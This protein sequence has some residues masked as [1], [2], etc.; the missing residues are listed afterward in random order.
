MSDGYS[1]FL[2]YA[3]QDDANDRG[4]VLAL[5]EHLEKELSLISGREIRIFVD[6]ASIE[7]GDEWRSRI[8][9]ALNSSVFLIAILTPL[10]FSRVECR[11]ELVEFHAQSRSRGMEKLILPIQYL[12]TP[13][14]DLDSPDELRAIAAR[15]QFEDWTELRLA[16]VDGAD[17]RKGV[18]RLAAFLIQRSEAVR[19]VEEESAR[20]RVPEPDQSRPGLID[21]LESVGPKFSTWLSHV[22][23]DE[24]RDAKLQAVHR[25]YD[26]RLA[27]APAVQKLAI[28]HREAV[29]SLPLAQESFG[30]AREYAA[31]TVEM[32]PIMTNLFRT[33]RTAP[34]LLREVE[35][36]EDGVAHA[37][38]R[39]EREIRPGAIEMKEYFGGLAHL[40]AIFRDLGQLFRESDVFRQEGNALVMQWSEEFSAVRAAAATASANE[41]GT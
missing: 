28:R 7:W 26:E 8:N 27:R 6:R 10:Y 14:L 38:V 2:S 4:R 35:D 37:R 34:L 9:E 41:G 30:L 21:L 33:L 1:I 19:V 16:D 23:D 11:R 18:N 13:G 15:V 29:D 3:H 20:R 17:Y 24:V 5:A 32:H 40:G 39:I 25:T 36:I 22:M 12:P 31:L